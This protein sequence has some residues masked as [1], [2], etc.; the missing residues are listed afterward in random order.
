MARSAAPGARPPGAPARQDR[1]LR[2]ALDIS[3]E[4]RRIVGRAAALV[5][6]AAEARGHRGLTDLRIRPAARAVVLDPDDRILLVRFRFPGG[7]LLG[8]PRR[9]H[10]A[11]R[12]PE[13]AI[14]RELAEEAG[15]SDVQIGPS[16]LDA[17]A[18]RPFIGGQW[19]GQ[20]EQYHLVRTPAFTPAPRLSWE[21][22]NAEYVYELRWWQQTEL[23]DAAETFAPRRLAELV[24]VARRRRPAGGTDRRRI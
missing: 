13:E 9:R 22:L 5:S 15:L 4:R 2:P 21:Q 7:D 18:H 8:Y 6:R 16:D 23:R 11:G 20:R 1:A 14:R 19:D 10:R 3:G 17:A 24:R 12:D